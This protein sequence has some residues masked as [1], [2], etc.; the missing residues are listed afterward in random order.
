VATKFGMHVQRVILQKSKCWSDSGCGSR[1]TFHVPWHY[2]T[3]HFTI[4]P[5]ICHTVD[6]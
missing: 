6:R 1:I 5:N 2:E 3:G 4:L